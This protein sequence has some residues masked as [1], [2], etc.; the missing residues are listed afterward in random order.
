VAT[1][2]DARFEDADRPLRLRAEDVEDLAVLS[3]LLQDAV[4]TVGDAAFL[5]KKR[6][7]VVMVSRFRWEDAPLAERAGRAFERVRATLVVEN[8]L[9]ARARG[10]DLADR[11]AVL[12]VLNAVFEPGEDGAGVLR[13]ALAGGGDVAL[14]VEAIDVSLTDVARPH[15][16]RG[17]PEHEG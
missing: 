13:L 8:V 6:R 17:R 1:Q 7:F 16:A 5:P 11:A 12:S 4:A 2:P 10:V 9:S 3:A 15:G 14:D